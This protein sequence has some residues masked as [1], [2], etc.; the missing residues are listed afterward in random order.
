MRYLFQFAGEVKRHNKANGHG[1]LTL[2][3]N[4]LDQNHFST[5][6]QWEKNRTAFKHKFEETGKI[7]SKFWKS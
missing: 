3:G 5:L 7:V 4:K 6:F 2:V 1:S